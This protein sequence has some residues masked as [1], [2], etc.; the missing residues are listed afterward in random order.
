MHGKILNLESA[1][2]GRNADSL[3]EDKLNHCKISIKI[4]KYL[5]K[6]VYSEEA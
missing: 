5:F 4:S 2:A 6:W 1:L 3:P